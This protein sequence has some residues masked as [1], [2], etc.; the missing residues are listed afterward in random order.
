M[1]SLDRMRNRV[2]YYGEVTRVNI[3][4]AADPQ[5][6]FKQPTLMHDQRIRMREDKLKNLKRALYFSYQAAIVQKYNP[7]EPKSYSPYFRCL[8]NH[9]KLKVDYEDKTISIPF[10]ENSVFIDPVIDNKD[11]LETNFTNGT[12]FKWIHGNKEKWVPDTYWMVFMQYSEEIAYFRGE[13]KKTEDEAIIS[14]AE[15]RK[16]NY[17]VC[18]VGPNESKIDWN[19]KNGV[20][21]NNLNYSKIMYITRDKNTEAFFRRFTR[22][23]VNGLPHEVQA[24]NLRNGII[25]A[26]L[27]ET[28]KSTDEQIEDMNNNQKPGN[29][30]SEP[31][32]VG[33]D[34]L[35]P[36]DDV[37]YEAKNAGAAPWILTIVSDGLGTQLKDLI[38]SSIDENK[39]KISVIT[40]KPYKLGFDIEYG[41]LKKH[42]TIKSL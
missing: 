23:L 30:S 16:L 4:G 33:P 22:V 19:N 32:I 10:E 27:K 28:Y 11:M 9:D 6:N 2:G 14:T 18:T 31:S 3:Y 1:S 37:T 12:V 21:W 42:I 17:K 25:V 7:D 8:I 35:Y 41:T 34:V 5:G 39:I 29:N 13:I 36:G 20:V 40:L 26:A 24:K 38:T 15:G